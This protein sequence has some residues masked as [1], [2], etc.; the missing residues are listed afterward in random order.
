MY[1]SKVS[2]QQKVRMAV[3]KMIQDNVAVCNFGT[4]CRYAPITNATDLSRALR[5]LRDEG[6]VDENGNFNVGRAKEWLEEIK[7]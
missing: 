3:S 7:G 6:I 5:V 2:F 4:I 1:P